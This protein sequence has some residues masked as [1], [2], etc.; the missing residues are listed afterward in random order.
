MAYL[1]SDIELVADMIFIY[2][3]ADMM[4]IYRKVHH[5]TTW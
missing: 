4:L 2:V 1:Y 3:D 5:N